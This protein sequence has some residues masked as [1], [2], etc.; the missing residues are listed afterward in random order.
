MADLPWRHFPTPLKFL[1]KVWASFA[2]TSS[3]RWNSTLCKTRS[4]YGILPEPR[5]RVPISHHFK[6]C[7]RE[8]RGP[9]FLSLDREIHRVHGFPFH[10][11][12]GKIHSLPSE[13]T[14]GCGAKSRWTAEGGMKGAGRRTFWPRVRTYAGA[15][16]L[17]V[18]EMRHRLG[19]DF[20]SGV[21][22]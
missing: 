14:G 6:R 9:F 2:A 4:T 3:L 7:K 8:K 18:S 11:E 10:K 16:R 19:R 22:L 5:K 13:R 21:N 1:K 12:K 15:C 20:P 17:C